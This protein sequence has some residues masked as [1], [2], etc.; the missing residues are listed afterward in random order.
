MNSDKALVWSSVMRLI[1][2]LNI[3]Y[4]ENSIIVH[5]EESRPVKFYLEELVIADRLLKKALRLSF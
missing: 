1:L 5:R 4:E 2:A 3:I